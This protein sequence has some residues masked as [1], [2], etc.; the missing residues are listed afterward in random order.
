MGPLALTKMKCPDDSLDGK[1]LGLLESAAL[2][3]IQNGFLYFDLPA[4]TG[5]LRFVP[6]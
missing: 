5:T 1:F 2:F 4:D 6:Q 3:F